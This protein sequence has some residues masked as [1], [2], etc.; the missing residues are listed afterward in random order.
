M[1]LPG[2]WFV[3]ILNFPLK[4]SKSCNFTHLFPVHLALPVADVED[5]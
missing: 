1:I 3:Q 5:V 2:R 4:D